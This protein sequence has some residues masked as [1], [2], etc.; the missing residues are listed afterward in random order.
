MRTRFFIASIFVLALLAYRPSYANT[1][2]S[3]RSN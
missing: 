2:D 1:L 3:T